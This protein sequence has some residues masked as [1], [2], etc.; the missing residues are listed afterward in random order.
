MAPLRAVL[1]TGIV[2]IPIISATELR[3]LLPNAR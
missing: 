2:I 1:D 3:S